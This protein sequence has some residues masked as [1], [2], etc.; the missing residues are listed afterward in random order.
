[1]N[2]YRE[3]ALFALATEKPAE[4]ALSWKTKLGDFAASADHL[5]H[6]R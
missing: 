3:E 1:M 6:Q 4:N 5:S 2:P